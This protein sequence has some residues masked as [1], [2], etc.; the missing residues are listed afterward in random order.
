MFTVFFNILREIKFKNN[1]VCC[2]GP[3]ESLHGDWLN[4]LIHMALTEVKL[5]D[6]MCWQLSFFAGA[7]GS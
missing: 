7:V 5:E 6:V 1:C 4:A 3:K 2:S